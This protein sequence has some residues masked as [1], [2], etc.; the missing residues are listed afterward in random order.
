MG[1]DPLGI[2]TSNSS[3]TNGLSSASASLS[4]SN[5][6]NQNAD[7]QAQFELLVELRRF[8]NID[9]FQRGYYQVRL[10]LKCMNKQLPIKILLQLEKNPNNINLSG[11]LKYFLK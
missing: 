4:A 3:N 10:Q 8:I 6:N 9:V 5:S 11:K 1:S 2:M 7:I